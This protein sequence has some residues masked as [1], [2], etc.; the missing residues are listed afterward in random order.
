MFEQDRVTV[1]QLGRLAPNAWVVRM[2][3]VDQILRVALP[4][5]GLCSRA[6]SVA[7]QKPQTWA[8]A[9]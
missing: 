3:V 4:P 8:N 7:W 2:L 9:G 1:L 5:S 6:T